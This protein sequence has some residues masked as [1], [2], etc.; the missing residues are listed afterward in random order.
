MQTAD[1]TITLSGI[2]FIQNGPEWEEATS[3]LFSDLYNDG[4]ELKDARAVV[5][6]TGIV[7]TPRNEVTTKPGRTLDS[8]PSVKVT[9]SQDVMMD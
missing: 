1:L 8:D 7:E 4:F 9:Y 3:N 6:I 5:M 2:T